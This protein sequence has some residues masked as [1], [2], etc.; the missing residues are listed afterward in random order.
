MVRI[1]KNFPKRLY[2]YN[3]FNV[4]LTK[5]GR[6]R[7]EISP[8]FTF[9]HRFRLSGAVDGWIPIHVGASPYASLFCPYRA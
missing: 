5:K 2:P 7:S 6:F 9:L 4:F 1:Y 3:L 8:I